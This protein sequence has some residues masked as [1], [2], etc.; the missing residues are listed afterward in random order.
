[1]KIGDMFSQVE[2]PNKIAY[3]DCWLNWTFV[4][5]VTI[6]TSQICVTEEISSNETEFMDAG[7][8]APLA[9]ILA[10]RG[11]SN[12]LRCPINC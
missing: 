12:P 4:C 8:L 1:M 5:K 10:S 9:E 11:S 7:T 3:L 6:H 2:T